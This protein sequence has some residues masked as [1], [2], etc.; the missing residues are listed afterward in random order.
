MRIILGSVS[1]LPFKRLNLMQKKR[2]KKV[3]A[4]LCAYDLE[5]QPRVTQ[6]RYNPVSLKKKK[7]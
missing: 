3:F 4:Y 5:M 1:L 2:K 7:T 6:L